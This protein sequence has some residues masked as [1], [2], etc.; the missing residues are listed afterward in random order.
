MWM[1]RVALAL[2]ALLC[3]SNTAQATDIVL[4]QVTDGTAETL[5][6]ARDYTAGAQVYLD[7]VNAHGGIQGRKVTIATRQSADPAAAATVMRNASSAAD[8]VVLFAVVGDAA[9]KA[10]GATSEF[11]AG[12]F[13]MFAPLTGNDLLPRQP[14]YYLRASY[15]DEADRIVDWFGANRVASMAVVHAAGMD[16]AVTTIRDRSGGANVHIVGDIPLATDYTS[17]ARSAASTRAQVV[18]VLAD[19]IATGSF[20]KAFHPLSPGTFVVALSNVSQQTLLELAGPESAVGTILTQVTPGPRS[21]QFALVREH[22][23][24][25][26]QFRDEP[27]SNLTIEGFLA[28]KALVGILRTIAGPI[29]R[30][31]V[32]KALQVPREFDAGGLVLNL[33]STSSRASR[34]ADLTMIRRD[35]TLIQ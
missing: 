22:L 6:A 10:L 2:C 1:A 9:I 7:F 16:D 31:S 35:G 34:F 5:D 24:T 32:M 21:T 12:H 33:G 14:V 20:I 13:A 3:M 18:V 29:D 15:R 8:T 4:L 26:K 28:A 27:A 23:A 11:R 25:M 17:A 19:T 30:A